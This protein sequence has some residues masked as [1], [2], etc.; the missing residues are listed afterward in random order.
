MYTS[1][2]GDVEAGVAQ[3][4]RQQQ[5]LQRVLPGD[6]MAMEQENRIWHQ[7]PSFLRIFKGI[8]L[9]S[10]FQF[11]INITFKTE[12]GLLAAYWILFFSA[13]VVYYFSVK[14][15]DHLYLKY[16]GEPPGVIQVARDEYKSFMGKGKPPSRP[17]PP[18]SIVEMVTRPVGAA[19]KANAKKPRSAYGRRTRGGLYGDSKRK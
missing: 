7:I 3:L 15:V 4:H 6:I 1:N 16:N 8:W 19:T 17:E 12:Q 13:W 10:A 9:A 11:T 5:E 2:I 18:D 14:Y